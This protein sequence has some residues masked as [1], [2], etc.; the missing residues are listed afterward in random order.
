[1]G[2]IDLKGQNQRLKVEIDERIQCCLKHGKFLLGPKVAELE[3][4][5]AAFVGA[6]FCIILAN[7]TDA[8]QV[9]QMALNIGHGDEIITPRFT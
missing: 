4:K 7:G 9:A 5:L 3:E 1:M 8:L 6:K 2:F